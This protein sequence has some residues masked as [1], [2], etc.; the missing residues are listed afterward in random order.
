MTLVLVQGTDNWCPVGQGRAVCAL[1]NGSEASGG[2]PL[3]DAWA[4]LEPH[5]TPI[6]V[7]EQD[8]AGRVDRR[9]AHR[10]GAFARRVPGCGDPAGDHAQASGAGVKRA[11]R[12]PG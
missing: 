5:D 7:S 3:P 9:A 8:A 4:A 6:G 12:R 2:G 10:S 1:H 11:G